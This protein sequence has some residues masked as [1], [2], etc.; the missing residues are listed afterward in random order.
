V[1]GRWSY[2]FHPT[3]LGGEEFYYAQRTSFDRTKACIILKHLAPGP[4]TIFPRGLQPEHEYVV[5]SDS[6]QVTTVR[7]GAD[8]ME[9]ASP[10]K[11]RR[12]AS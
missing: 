3:V 11:S 1:A 2:T 7:S 8:L 5:G 12:P 6:T 10:S 9:T 4:I